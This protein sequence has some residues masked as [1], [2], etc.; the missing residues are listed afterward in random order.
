[1]DVLDMPKASMLQS[2]PNWVNCQEE[3]IRVCLFDRK[4]KPDKE[5]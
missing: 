3:V 1:M 2:Q 4:A 5:R